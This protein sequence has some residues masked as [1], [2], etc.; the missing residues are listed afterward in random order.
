MH[1]SRIFCLAYLMSS[2]MCFCL[3]GCTG[4]S[5][6]VS[7]T[8]MPEALDGLKDLAHLLEILQAERGS[9]PTKKSDFEKFDVMHPAA[10]TLIPNGTI[11]YFL[12]GKVNQKGGEPTIVAM[13][14]NADKTGGWVLLSSGEVHDLPADQVASMKTSGKPL[15]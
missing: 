13:Q 6:T 15:Q 11:V 3:N 10:G 7:T 1:L 8:G 12:G 14:A 2:L 4:N 9:L 5:A